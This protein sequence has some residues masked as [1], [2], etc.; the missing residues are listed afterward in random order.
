MGSG[1]FDWMVPAFPGEGVHRDAPL[2]SKIDWHHTKGAI[3]LAEEIG[4]NTLWV[5]DHFSLGVDQAE[6]EVFSMLGTI[7]G[8]TDSV[9]LGTLVASVTYRNPTLLGKIAT[10]LD[11]TSEGRFVLGLGAGWHKAEHEAYGY[12]FPDIGERIDRLDEALRIIQSMWTDEVTTVDGEF[13]Q[14]TGIRNNPPPVQEPHPPIMVGGGG[15]RML[16][17][18]AEHADIWNIGLTARNRGPSVGQKVEYLD[19]YIEEAERSPE[20]VEYSWLG[21]C[22]V[23]DSDQRL[24]EMADRIFPI[25]SAAPDQD[26]EIRS[27]EEARTAGDYFIGTPPEVTSQLQKAVDLGFERFQLIFVDYPN[28]DGMRLFADEVVEQVSF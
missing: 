8:L 23:A 4:F 5:P 13:Y 18:V 1:S 12:E 24:E 20:D 22:L 25:P 10:S 21:H 17:L 3:Q 11:V 28:L 14:A 7:A 16:R 6:L 2:Y 26:Y 19:G 27:I 9:Q 15:P